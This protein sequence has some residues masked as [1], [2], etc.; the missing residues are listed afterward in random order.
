MAQIFQV[1]QISRGELQYLIRV[2]FKDLIIECL[3]ETDRRNK[4]LDKNKLVYTKKEF[5]E[6]IGKSTSF[7][8]KERRAGR[9]KWKLIG[10]TVAI[11][12]E[13]LKKYI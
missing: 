8:D 5:A 1:T 12:A 10:G 6:V 9:I 13:E 3:E 11:K 4:K 2:E 7:V